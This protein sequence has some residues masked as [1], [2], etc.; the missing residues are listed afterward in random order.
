MAD[1]NCPKCKSRMRE[2]FIGD[3]ETLSRESRQNWG[4]GINVLGT[5][6]DNAYPVTTFRCE[7]CGYLE[8]YAF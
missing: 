7:K 1:K 5:G 8:N 2:G 3:K 6:M 4:T